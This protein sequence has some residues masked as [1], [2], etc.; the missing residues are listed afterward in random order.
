MTDS[1]F[2]YGF[3]EVQEVLECLPEI[4]KRQGL[5]RF[6]DSKDL[7]EAW[8]LANFCSTFPSDAKPQLRLIREEFPDGEILFGDRNSI[9]A[10]EITDAFEG[11]TNHPDKD[12]RIFGKVVNGELTGIGWNTN[13]LFNIAVYAIKMALERKISKNY[14]DP[15][16]LL[17]YLRD[18][19]D[20]DDTWK[21]MTEQIANN[22]TSE[23]LSS[24][25]SVNI[26]SSDGRRIYTIT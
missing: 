9:E 20:F 10:Y 5:G 17:I 11:G 8:V 16:N 4:A 6:A 24:F 19:P 13:T 14:S 2:L 25:K 3:H 7:R 23:D 18:V 12:S 21:G 22:V 1:D 26:L 15:V